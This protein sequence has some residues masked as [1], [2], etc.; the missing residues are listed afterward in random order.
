MATRNTFFQILFLII[1]GID[2]TIMSVYYMTHYY[3]SIGPVAMQ[4]FQKMQINAKSQITMA[5][6]NIFPNFF[7]LILTDL[8]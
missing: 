3:A 6:T 8:L 7:C 4:I 1:I 2:H 5:I